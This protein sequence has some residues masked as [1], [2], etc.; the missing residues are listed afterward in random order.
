MWLDGDML[1]PYDYWQYFRNIDDQDI[2][3][4]LRF[5]TD[6]PIDEIKK[7]ESLKNQEVNEAKKALA[8]EVTKICHGDEEAELA[9]SS[10]VSVFENG[11]SS[12]L[13]DYTIT[14]KQV[15]NGISLI[16]LLYDIGLEPSK[17]AAKRL[18]QGNGCKVNDYTI[19][20]INYI[21]NSKSFKGQSFIKLSAGKKRHIKVMVS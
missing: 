20:D 12:L 17:G 6:L 4:F 5:F 10:A 16:D 2:G 11:D 9:Q 18:I 8:T 7:L 1:K 15:A 14:K 21:I 19:N 13:P 3:R